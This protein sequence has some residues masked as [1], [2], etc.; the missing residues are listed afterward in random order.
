MKN[1]PGILLGSITVVSAL[2]CAGAVALWVHDRTNPNW[3]NDEIGFSTARS[4]YTISS[5]GGRVRLSGPPKATPADLSEEAWDA[6]RRLNNLDIDWLRGEPRKGTPAAKLE[7]LGSPVLPLLRGLDSPHKFGA[8]AVLLDRITF[9]P[10]SGLWNGNWTS[11]RAGVGVQFVDGRISVYGVRLDDDAA[12]D[13]P[14][15]FPFVISPETHPDQRSR[16]SHGQQFTTRAIL[17][18]RFDR[19]MLNIS[20]GWL[21][22][23]LMILPA[24]FLILELRPRRRFTPGRCAECGYDLRATP[25]RCPECGRLPTGE[26]KE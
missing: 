3:Y 6:L 9:P 16:V 18:D 1:S 13:D 23:A 2:L 17:H 20:H 10:T 22:L 14:E 19:T 24:R 26:T 5:R 4:H 25:E 8:A 11:G 21:I 12:K 15:S 7:E